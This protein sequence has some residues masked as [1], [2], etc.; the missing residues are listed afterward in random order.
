MTEKLILRKPII[1]YSELLILVIFT[2]AT[3]YFR[4]E[5]TFL[6]ISN[7]VWFTYTIYKTN[8]RLK[9][10]EPKIIVSKEGIKFCDDDIQIDWEH[11]KYIFVDS[12]TVGSGKNANNIPYLRVE[13]GNRT[14]SK[15]IYDYQFSYR[16]LER[17]IETYWGRKIGNKSEKLDNDVI[18]SLNSSNSPEI[19]D[20]I[21]IYKRINILS[22]LLIL[23]V[24]LSFWI[25]L[26][27]KFT[28]PYFI[29]IGVPF[30][31]ASMFVFITTQEKKFRNS[32]PMN[33]LTDEEFLSLLI[34]YQVKNENSPQ[35][36][37]SGLIGIGVIGIII[38][39]ISYLISQ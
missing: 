8:Q 10:R 28:F 23:I 30:T 24:S 37:K 29:A 21:K 36:T 20:N 31:F 19:I 26:Q 22:M 7:L 11:I 16:K 25:F 6:T 39:L 17:L 34:K 15:K 14:I 35:A 38:S 5:I 3:I 32:T 4:F 27:V 2:G 33:N 13:Y 9:D 1:D 12:K 18:K